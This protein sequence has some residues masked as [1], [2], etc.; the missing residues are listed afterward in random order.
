M[1]NYLKTIFKDVVVIVIAESTVIYIF[2]RDIFMNG[3]TTA[4]WHIVLNW[5][6]V[7]FVF[8]ALWH[9]LNF[10]HNN[11]F[12]FD[13]MSKLKSLS[14]DQLHLF[15]SIGFSDN[16]Q[17]KR[18]SINKEKEIVNFK[19]LERLG[20]VKINNIDNDQISYDRTSEC[21]DIFDET[22]NWI[23]YTITKKKKPF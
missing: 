9:F 8:V 23:Y 12:N 21:Q 13:A 18:L 3:L 19:A 15:I 1:R 17:L 14:K 7:L 20:L 10:I 11:K 5:F 16:I 6:I 4:N 22:F 2:Y